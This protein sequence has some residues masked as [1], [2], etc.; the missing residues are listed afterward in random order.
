MKHLRFVKQSP[1]GWPAGQ[2]LMM[3]DDDAAREIRGGYAVEVTVVVPAVPV[4]PTVS[5]P[6]GKEG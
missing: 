4:E 2:E 5:K 3:A 6:A 1:N